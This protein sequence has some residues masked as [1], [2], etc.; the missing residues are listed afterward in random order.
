MRR[1]TTC[2]V[3]SAVLAGCESATDP[4]ARASSAPS[5]PAFAASNG[6]VDPNTLIPVPP[7]GAECHA[8]GQWIICHTAL[9][10]APV[11]EPGLELPCGT[12]YETGTDD[13]RGI[14][15]YN[16]DRRLAKR[17][18]TQDVELEWSLSPTGAGPTVTL[19]VHANWRNDYAVPG[20]ESTG[21]QITHGEATLQAPGFGV[22][23]HNAGLDLPD[24]THHG[25][26]RDISDPAVALEVCSA[27][28]R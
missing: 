14:R 13:R 23:A 12:E 17:F 11:N 19:T 6:L 3:L 24:E 20:D 4:M 26:F 10:L 9:S 22:I 18:V 7:P 1:F 5:A 25:A 21:P 2:L 15:W 8:D 27:L 16:S 28:T